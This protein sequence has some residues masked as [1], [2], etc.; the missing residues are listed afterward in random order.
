MENVLKMFLNLIFHT[1]AIIDCK[2]DVQQYC[3]AQ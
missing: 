3:K 1:D 2:F